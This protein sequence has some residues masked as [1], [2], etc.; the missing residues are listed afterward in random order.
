MNNEQSSK[1]KDLNEDLASQN[2]EKTVAKIAA[3]NAAKDATRRR[4]R[5]ARPSS[6][7]EAQDATLL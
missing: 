4:L 6:L 3:E 2:K 5:D 7:S 1:A